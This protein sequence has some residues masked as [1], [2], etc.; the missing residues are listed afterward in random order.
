M[1]GHELQTQRVGNEW[2]FVGECYVN[3]HIAMWMN[4]S[5]VKQFEREVVELNMANMLLVWIRKSGANKKEKLIHYA[6]QTRRQRN[7]CSA[8]K[9]RYLVTIDVSLIH[10]SFIGYRVCGTVKPVGWCKGHS[11]LVAE[12]CEDFHPRDWASNLGAQRGWLMK[13]FCTDDHRE[14]GWLKQGRTHW[15]IGR[16]QGCSIR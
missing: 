13:L 4:I 12:D 11:F 3:G 15:T 1:E 6:H 10:R 5:R 9:I 16:R 7:R 14:V 8:A 2:K